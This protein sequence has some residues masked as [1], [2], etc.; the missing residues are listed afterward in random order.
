[1]CIDYAMKV[2]KH[3]PQISAV[4]TLTTTEAA[5]LLGLPKWTI[6]EFVKRGEVE[7][8]KGLRTKEFRFLPNAFDHLF[9][10]AA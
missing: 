1:M 4:K 10:R 6:R 3:T 5:A 9:Q 8:V 2:T 7:R